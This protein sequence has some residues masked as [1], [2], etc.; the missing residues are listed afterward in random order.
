[1]VMH[2]NVSL[3]TKRVISRRRITL[4]KVVHV[5]V[6]TS[7]FW[8]PSF[9]NNVIQIHNNTKIVLE[10]VT[11]LFI[12][13]EPLTAVCGYQKMLQHCERV[14]PRSHFKSR[15]VEFDCPSPE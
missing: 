1:M 5:N 10:K 14:E 2:Y 9:T 11:F 3:G 8:K 6:L 4:L 13:R 12:Y 7:E 15:P